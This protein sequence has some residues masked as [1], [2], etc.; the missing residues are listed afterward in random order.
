M[1]ITQIEYALAVYSKRNFVEA[2][3]SCSISQPTLSM[4]LKKLEEEIGYV[5]FDRSKS[6]LIVTDEGEQFILQS[7]IVLLEYKKLF[8]RDEKELKGELVVGIIPTI[9]PYLIPLFLPQFLGKFPQITIQFRELQTHE[10]IDELKRDEIHAAILATP[11]KESF[12][13]EKVLYYEPFI[14]YVSSGHRLSKKQSIS[15]D[16]IE[17]DGLWLLEEGHCLRN[18]IIKLCSLKRKAGGPVFS[19][20][21]LETLIRLVDRN[22]GMTILPMLAVEQANEKNIRKFSHDIPVREVS[23]VTARNFYKENLINALESS[24]LDSI[25][26]ELDIPKRKKIHVLKPI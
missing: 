14:P 16:E 12:L 21:S 6:P 20:G 13:I 7:K 11:L 19:G 26:S 1:T 18:Q 8:Q 10:I 5:L 9:A 24:I 2:A 3:K 17:S 23:L 22:L 25:P 4:Q 15:P